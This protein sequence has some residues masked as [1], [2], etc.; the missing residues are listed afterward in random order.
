[1]KWLCLLLAG[2]AAPA[3][4]QSDLPPAELVVR[5]LDAQPGVE[6]A[7]ARVDAARADDEA[8]RRGPNE[9]TAQGTFS[10]RTVDGDGNYAEYDTTI[11][12]AF[13]L[14]GKARLDR[15]AGE[16]GID[17]ARNQMEDARHQAALTLA[18]LWYDWLAAGELHRNAAALV[19]NQRELAR[20][21]S[22]RVDV[23]DA[24][25]LELD[26]AEAALA[27]AEAQQ[28]DAAARRDR[29]R[30]LLG[31]R[32]PDMPLPAEPP[33]LAEP[34]LPAEG[35]DE[36]QRLIVERSH[37]IGAASDTAERQQV[38]A[39][40]ARADRFADPSFGVRVFS[41]RGGQE[42]G[43]GLFASLPLGG[44]HRRALA[45]RATADAAAARAERT[46][47]ERTVAGNAIADAAEFRSR[48]SAWQASR[49]AVRRAEASAALST[50]GQ[51]L[52]AID[53]SD[54][55]YAERQANEARA[56]E[57]TAREA[58]ARLLLKLR[59]DAHSLWID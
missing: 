18:Q 58:A 44:G 21:T 8:L 53:L 51:R 14:P 24:A 20:A 42:Q 2:T 1:M 33:S 26:Q 49:A 17:V 59:I 29:A 39:R 27:L 10:R 36:L 30:A 31:A 16:L 34:A 50:R 15:R 25:Q 48:L 54:R 11:S 28:G 12:K 43:A 4:A 56:Q 7:T 13:R 22:A 55:L 37:E 38:L 6:A 52:G 41:E 47:V 45:N 19:A 57:I 23:R 46:A 9:I 35:L 3:M 32:F 5:A 40:R